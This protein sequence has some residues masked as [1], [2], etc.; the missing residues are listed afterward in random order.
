MLDGLRDRHEDYQQPYNRIEHG[1]KIPIYAQ[2]GNENANGYEGTE[3]PGRQQQTW[4]RDSGQEQHASSGKTHM[5]E[6]SQKRMV[7]RLNR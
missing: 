4:T 7:L 2:G 6:N 5:K 3:Y 1:G